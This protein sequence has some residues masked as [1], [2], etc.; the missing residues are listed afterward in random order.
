[1]RRLELHTPVRIA[2][3]QVWD[4]E[5]EE[6]VE[7]AIETTIGRLVFNQILPPRLRYT[8]KTNRP[9]ARAQLREVVADCY[10]LLGRNET[11]HLVDGIKSV[12]FRYATQGGMTIAVDDIRVPETKKG[13]LEAADRRVAD[14][15]A[16][17]QRGL[18]T[19][20]ERYARVVEVWRNTTDEV[21]AR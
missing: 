16:Q 2:R 3:V 4:D 13:L 10:R 8:D 11:A 14:I 9:M 21:A 1:M 6:L 19:D 5:T 7:T 18:I 12:G 17:Y 20:D 15:D